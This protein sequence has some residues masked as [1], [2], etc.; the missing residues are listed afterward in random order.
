MML[1]KMFAGTYMFKTMFAEE[2]F[3]YTPL[4]K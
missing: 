3:S 4:E 2:N 1:E